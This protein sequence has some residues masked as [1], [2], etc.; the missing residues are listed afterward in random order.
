MSASTSLSQASQRY[1]YTL[2]L[3]TYLDPVSSLP[4][5]E[6]I[7]L[8]NWPNLFCGNLNV[9]FLPKEFGRNKN[10][11]K[12]YFYFGGHAFLFSLKIRFLQHVLYFTSIIRNFFLTTPTS[13]F[14]PMRELSDV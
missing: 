10:C 1:T 3:R 11:S 7:N 9:Y 13:P 2:C 6:M 14:P 12:K 8:V 5:N 4:K